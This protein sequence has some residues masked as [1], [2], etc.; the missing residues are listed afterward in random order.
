[1]GE[2]RQIERWLS[3]KQTS[4]MTGAP[5]PHLF[6]TPNLALKALIESGATG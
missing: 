5:L 1:M 2:R 3:L 6:L 4:P